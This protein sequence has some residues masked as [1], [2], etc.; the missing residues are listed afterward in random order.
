MKTL[1]VYFSA[2]GITK[3]AAK[4]IATTI[5]ADLFEI[6]P[7]I[8]Y[9]D[10]D[11][12]WNDP[13]SRSSVE[14]KEG[15]SRPEIKNTVTNID[16]YERVVLGF[17]IWWYV[18]PTIINTFIENNNLEG[19]E[20]YVFATSGSSSIDSTYKH[21]KEEYPRINFINGKR[22][23]REVSDNEIKEWLN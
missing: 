11:L 18:A 13:N 14:M 19:K 21:L 8:P 20:V 17:P 9:T 23:T 16:E 15:K 10:A 22:F 12:N 2:S 5:N 7:S 1:V 4:K 6:E 3:E